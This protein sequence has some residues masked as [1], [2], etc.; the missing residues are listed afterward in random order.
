MRGRG[1][2]VRKGKEK[3]EIHREFGEVG[4]EG[5]RG[6]EKVKRAQTCI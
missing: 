5:G 4:E 2:A 3:K 6:R 1:G